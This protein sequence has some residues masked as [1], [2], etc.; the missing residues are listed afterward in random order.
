MIKLNN[1]THQRAVDTKRTV[2]APHT[3]TRFAPQ[4]L[5]PGEPVEAP[6]HGRQRVQGPCKV[7]IVQE[8]S[9]YFISLNIHSKSQK[10]Q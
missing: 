1:L 7:V 8:F 2:R 6:G 5:R 4:V 10:I 3:K 9:L